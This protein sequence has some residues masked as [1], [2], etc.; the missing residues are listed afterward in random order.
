MIKTK[1]KE[2]EELSPSLEFLLNPSGWKEAIRAKATFARE[3]GRS[4]YLEQ[5]K[6]KLEKEKMAP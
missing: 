2:K 1:N 5:L 3:I 6:K 4:Y